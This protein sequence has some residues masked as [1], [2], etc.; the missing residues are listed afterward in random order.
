M[1]R[2]QFVNKQ[3]EIWGFDYISDLFDK[4]YEPIQM[5]DN[6]TGEVKWTWYEGIRP[7]FHQR[8]LARLSQ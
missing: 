4:G 5:R 8:P 6:F 2:A 7:I 1:T 3:I